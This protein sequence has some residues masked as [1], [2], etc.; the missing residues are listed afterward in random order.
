MMSS[1]KTVER[2]YELM[3]IENMVHLRQTAVTDYFI[4]NG[5]AKYKSD[6][7]LYRTKPSGTELS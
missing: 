5:L 2:D 4:S 1:L 7:C 3:V 6:I